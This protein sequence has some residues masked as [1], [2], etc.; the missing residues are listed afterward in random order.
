M[1]T[2]INKKKLSETYKKNRIVV[3]QSIALIAYL[4]VENSWIF[5]DMKIAGSPESQSA[6]KSAFFI[7]DSALTF[8]LFLTL[9]KALDNVRNKM[10]QVQVKKP[11]IAITT[12]VAA[13][14]QKIVE[15]YWIF[16][17]TPLP[18]QLESSAVAKFFYLTILALS[19]ATIIG[20]IG[21]GLDTI[22]QVL[23]SNEEEN[24]NKPILQQQV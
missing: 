17:E 3:N 21:Y 13:A 15:N 16:T 1:L 18:G 10:A 19:Y 20:S 9:A 4:L 6:A 7:A 14:G 22:Q 11:S 24:E 2:F 12:G 8:T 5:T 23:S